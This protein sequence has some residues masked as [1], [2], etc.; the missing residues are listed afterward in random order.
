MQHSIY[1]GVIDHGIVIHPRAR[2]VK[3]HIWRE[4]LEI[5]K[6]HAMHE[7]VAES[8]YTTDNN[9]FVAFIVKIFD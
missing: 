3:L 8:T 7:H 5:L 6:H 9:D 4:F 1:V 2:K